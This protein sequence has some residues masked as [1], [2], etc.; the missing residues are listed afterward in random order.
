MKGV[1]FAPA[2]YWSLTAEQKKDICSGCGPKG[3]LSWIIPD[4]IYGLRISHVCDIHD[5]MY[6]VGETIEDKESADRSFL[7][8]MLR[9]IEVQNSWAWLAWL[10]RKRAGT[11]Y[12]AVK[13]FGGPAFWAGKNK[14]E[15]MGV[16][17]A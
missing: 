11:Y 12:N 17:V 4:T 14:P 7:N 2:E 5:W 16:V 13:L 8:N 6:A 3:L 15:E 10:R 1:L 9:L